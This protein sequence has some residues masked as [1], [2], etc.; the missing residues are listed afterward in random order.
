MQKK[1]IIV[2]KCKSH[3]AG[4]V[5]FFVLMLVVTTI[6]VFAL[7]TVAAALLYIPVLIILM[8]MALYYLSWQIRIDKKGITRSVFF[9]KGKQYTFTMLQNVVKS[10]YVSER[11]FTIRM[12]FLDGKMIQ[13][14]MDDENAIQAVRE[15]QRHCSIKS[16]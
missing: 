5:T 9:R 2:K 1:T 8:P 3:R 16:N 7:R 6:C 10:Y 12:Y 14:R 13:F 4:I 11:N 15:L